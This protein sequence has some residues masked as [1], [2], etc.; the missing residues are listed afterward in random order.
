M[1]PFNEV[2][3]GAREALQDMV[4]P[5]RWTVAVFVAREDG[6][7]RLLVTYGG[8]WL[9]TLLPWS[10]DAAPSPRVA[11]RNL[12]GSF[13]DSVAKERGQAGRRPIYEDEYGT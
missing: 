1:E 8:E 9:R 2:V 3:A 4:D 11:A 7:Y 6:G 12:V 13:L 10:V 5:A